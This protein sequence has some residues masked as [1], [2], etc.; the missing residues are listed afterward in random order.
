MGVVLNKAY[1]A[2][3]N[4]MFQRNNSSIAQKCE[5]HHEMSIYFIDELRHNFS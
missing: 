4:T 3:Y 2:S 5:E 1:Y